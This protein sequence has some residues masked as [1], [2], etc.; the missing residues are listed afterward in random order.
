MISKKLISLTTAAFLGTFVGSSYLSFPTSEFR[1]TTIERRSINYN[2]YVVLL[3]DMQEGWKSSPF[4][5]DVLHDWKWDEKVENQKKVLRFA[6]EKKIPIVFLELFSSGGGKTVAELEEIIRGNYKRFEKTSSSGFD[7]TVNRDKK[8]T[9][10]GVLET[11]LHSIKARTL[12]IMGHHK[13]ECVY[14]TAFQGRENGFQI[15]TANDLLV[16]SDK[17]DLPEGLRIH[18]IRRERADK[19]Y[20]D[21]VTLYSSVDDLLK[22]L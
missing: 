6:K 7:K 17:A 9:D 19:F 12:I 14:A 16:G 18:P 5:K 15:V 22:H 10:D 11:Y 21:R 8:R 1:N 2:N 20:R 13:Y 4:L 3:V